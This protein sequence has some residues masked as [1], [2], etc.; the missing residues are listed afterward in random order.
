VLRLPGLARRARLLSQRFGL[1]RALGRPAEARAALDEAERESMAAGDRTHAASVRVLKQAAEPDARRAVDELRRIV[2]E[3]QVLGD[4]GVEGRAW[5][6]LGNRLSELGELEDAR[7]AL[8]RAVTTC[9]RVGDGRA[10]ALATMR[11]GR[12]DHFEGHHAA[13]QLRFEEA[14]RGFT[15]AGDL[16]NADTARENHAVVS[17]ELGALDDAAKRFEQVLAGAR[18]RGDRGIEANVGANLGEVALR[19]GR[20]DEARSRLEQAMVLARVGGWRVIEARTLGTVGM[21][22]AHLGRRA[23]A[24]RAWTDAAARMR[25]VGLSAAAHELDLAREI[26]RVAWGGVVPDALWE[27]LARVSDH[28]AVWLW[29]DLAHALIERGDLAA[30]RAIT[31]VRAIRDRRPPLAPL[32][33][34]LAVLDARREVRWGDAGAAARGLAGAERSLREEAPALVVVARPHRDPGRARGPRAGPARGGSAGGQ[35][36]AGRVRTRHP[37]PRGA[38]PTPRDDR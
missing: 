35:R 1:L 17:T 9:A 4:A 32:S 31:A 2:G 27:G 26:A 10:V 16:G 14:E 25:A 28:G 18:A 5:S 6:V 33:A 7:A 19:R 22:E 11:L 24:E 37:P 8:E 30:D 36:G 3:V 38:A 21:L 20:T 15:V 12:V 34:A 13:A 29:H 23:E